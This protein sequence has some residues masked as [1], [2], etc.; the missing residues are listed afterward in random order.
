MNRN[1]PSRKEKAK[2]LWHSKQKTGRAWAKT[3]PWKSVH[4]SDRA[5]HLRMAVLVICVYIAVYTCQF[6]SHNPLPLRF[7][8]QPGIHTFIL[9]ICLY[10]CFANE[11]IYTIFLDFIYMCYYTIFVFLFLTHFLGLFKYLSETGTVVHKIMITS[12]GHKGHVFRRI[13]IKLHLQTTCF[14]TYYQWT[15]SDWSL[16]N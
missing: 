11:I 14:Y 4:V 1:L 16:S 13:L 9:Y 5:G 8:P 12:N 15:I 6:Q 10:F 7:P 3:E 2:G